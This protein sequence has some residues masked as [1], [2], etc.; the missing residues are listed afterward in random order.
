MMK[1]LIIGGVAG[2]MSAAT[3]LRR[4]DEQAEIIIL[5]KGPYVSFANCGLPY[6]LAG[7]I[8]ERSDL[9]V[10]TAAQLTKRFKLDIRQNSEVTAINRT[11]QSVTVKTAQGTYQ[12]HYDRLI[13]STGA[14]PVVPAIEGLDSAQH[15]YTLRNVPDVD[16][17][18]A[19]AK[20]SQK[21]VVIG[22]GFIG[23]EIAEA[24]VNRG[25]QVTIVERGTHVL[26]SFD[27]EMAMFVQQALVQHGVTVLTKNAVTAFEAAGQTLVL[28]N[29]QTL[30]SDLTILA[31][32]VQPATQL[33]NAAG[34]QLGLRKGL[35]VNDHYQ[36]SDPLIYAIGDAIIVKQTTTNQDTLISLASP[37][38]RQGRQVADVLAGKNRLNRGSLGT[39]IV[40]VFEMAGGSTGLNESQLQAAGLTYQVLHLSGKSHAGY[41]PGAETIWLKLLFQ[42]QTGEL[43]GAQAVGPD[44]VDKRIDVLATAIKAG[45]TVDDLPE[46]E[47]SYAPPFGSAKDI[48]NLAGYAAQNLMAGD[49]DSLQWHELATAMAAG[50]QLVDVREPAEHQQGAI[51]GAINI[52]LDDLR[53]RMS[54]LPKSNHYIVSCASGL[55]SYLAE[56]IL[57]QNGYQVQNLDGAYALYALMQPKD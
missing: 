48:I 37:A 20:T 24:L 1:Y 54:E 7:E 44:G 43:F 27:I 9:L 10:K 12:E 18:L 6:Y 15:V 51:P 25:L 56:R 42:P 34:L 50:A 5:E 53:Q 29:G 16:Q 57:K 19:Q 32:G 22:A 3:R 13:L 41:F 11:D 47:L 46:L 14:Q 45:L 21:A 39:A 4:L 23:L 17:I 40:R 33:A 8:S 49:S 38:N 35:I 52:P 2:G 28:A 30:A 26:P 36:T 55:R 31:V